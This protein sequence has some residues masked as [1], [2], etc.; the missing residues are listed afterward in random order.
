MDQPGLVT[1]EALGRL[2]AKVGSGRLVSEPSIFWLGI[3]SLPTLG[4]PRVLRVTA[5]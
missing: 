4:K 5:F 3:P 1:Q 2:Q